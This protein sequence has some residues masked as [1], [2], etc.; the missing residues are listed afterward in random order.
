MRNVILL[1]AGLVALGVAGCGRLGGV[2]SPQRKAGLWQQTMQSDRTP[3]PMVSKWCFDAASDR[4]MPV[5][6]RRAG[7]RRG[8]MAGVCKVSATKS[9]D[10]YVT[11]SQCSFGGASLNSHS[12][13]SGDFA[14]KYTVV[15][16]VNVANSQ[17]PTRNGQHKITETW[18]YQGACPPDIGPGQVQT[19]NGEV[20]DM[21][22]LRGGRGGGGGGGGPG[23]GGGGGGGGQ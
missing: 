7:A 14:N 22:S 20:V 12:V 1:G 19:A 16:T 23:G 4:Q 3:A 18:A 2:S 17:D 9:G 8:P 21:A 5:L 6:G 13:V 15:R 11:D 10:G